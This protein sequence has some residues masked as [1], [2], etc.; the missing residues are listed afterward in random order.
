MKTFE[1]FNSFTNYL[2]SGEGQYL[3]SGSTASTLRTIKSSYFSYK[4]GLL[5]TLCIS[6]YTYI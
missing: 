6:K 3:V 1:K 2:Q 4:A 5:S